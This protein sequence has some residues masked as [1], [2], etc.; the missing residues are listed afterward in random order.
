[1]NALLK[2]VGSA[3]LL[4]G[5]VIV[6]FSCSVQGKGGEPTT[7]PTKTLASTA[8][9]SDSITSTISPSSPPPAITTD[10][11]NIAPTNPSPTPFS[12]LEP[13]STP[14]PKA[15]LDM[16]ER[17]ELLAQLMKQDE[18]CRLPCWWQIALGSPLEDVDRRFRSLGMPRWEIY[19]SDLG[20][21]GEMGDLRIGYSDPLDPSFYYVDVL[22]RLYTLQE[23]VAYIEVDVLRPL[24]D[25]GLAEFQRD[26]EPFFL[27]SI[28]GE[29]G[30]PS[31]V[32]LIPTSETYGEAI[33]QVLRLYYP[34]QGIT[35]S[36]VFHVSEM[37][38]DAIELCLDPANIYEL[39]LSLFAPDPIE[40]WASYLLPLEPESYERYSWKQRTGQDIMTLFQS[41]QGSQLPCVV[42]Q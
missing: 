18:S 9:Q 5:F 11:P 21:K 14:T 25:Y 26:W 6:T 13:S 7:S 4:M 34:E 38:E 8:E 22:V 1:M 40:Q 3:L 17:G 15:T 35:V 20:D 12:T 36:Y 27:D 31:S 33:D 10:M 29:F 28:I 23:R 42:L 32:Y 39:R 16:A 30:L 24:V 19:Q 2:R 41:L 37:A